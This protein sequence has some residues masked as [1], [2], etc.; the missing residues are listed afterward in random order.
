MH[1]GFSNVGMLGICKARTSQVV[2]KWTAHENLVSDGFFTPSGKKDLTISGSLIEQA[3]QE[4]FFVDT[5]TH[6]SGFIQ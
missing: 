4:R 5:E 3:E 6:A 1:D 2:N